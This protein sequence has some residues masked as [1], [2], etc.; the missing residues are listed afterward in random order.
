MKTQKPVIA[1]NINILLSQKG[2]I[3]LN[4]RS[5]KDKTKYTRKMKHK[6]KND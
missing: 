6:N 5:V 4:S 1:R 3:N 2:E